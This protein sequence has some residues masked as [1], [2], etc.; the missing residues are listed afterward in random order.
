MSEVIYNYQVTGTAAAGQTWDCRGKVK[1]RPGSFPD[2][3]HIAMTM[4]FRQ[5]CRGEA[6][7][8]GQPGSSCAGPFT[9]TGFAL[10]LEPIR[11]P[12]S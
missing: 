4:A 8:Y 1:G 7:A 6:V 5:L 11:K 12:R 3:L 9:I 10:E 2:L